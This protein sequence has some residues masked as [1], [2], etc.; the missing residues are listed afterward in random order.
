[1]KNKR[2]FTNPLTIEAF[3]EDFSGENWPLAFSTGYDS[4]NGKYYAVTTDHVNASWC[5]DVC[6]GDTAILFSKANKM[7]NLLKDYIECSYIHEEMEV[8]HQ[9]EDLILELESEIEEHRKGE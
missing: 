6:A 3:D 9:M 7:Y 4:C 8:Y 2:Y 1:M 5:D